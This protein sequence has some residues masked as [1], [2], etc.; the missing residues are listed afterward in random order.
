MAA[1]HSYWLST[2]V[3]HPA[4]LLLGKNI[5]IK[6]PNYSAGLQLE[7]S[8]SKKMHF[9]HCTLQQLQLIFI[10]YFMLKKCLSFTDSVDN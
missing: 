2:A 6:S 7:Y 5:R 3:N 9:L 4:Q 8:F 1:G 10:I